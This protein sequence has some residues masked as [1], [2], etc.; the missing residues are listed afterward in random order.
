[1]NAGQRGP[2]VQT[3]LVGIEVQGDPHVL[4]EIDI[5][6]SLCHERDNKVLK[7]GL[8]NSSSRKVGFILPA[9]SS[10]SVILVPNPPDCHWPLGLATDS[11][12]LSFAC[13]GVC[14][15]V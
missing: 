8:K 15:V 14:R 7:R 1:M 5:N 4:E 3:S 6:L 13:V 12:S 11:F 10:D 2:W 9:V